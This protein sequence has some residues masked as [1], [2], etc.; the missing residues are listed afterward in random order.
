MKETV[1]EFL[2][3]GGEIQIIPRGEGKDQIRMRRSTQS[4]DRMVYEKGAYGNF[5]NRK[6][7]KVSHVRGEEAAPHDQEAGPEDQSAGRGA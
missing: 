2:A 3:R 4:K 5:N 1:E 7:Y 6:G